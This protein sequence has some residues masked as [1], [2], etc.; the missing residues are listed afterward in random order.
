M[1]CVRLSGPVV[2]LS[3]IRV[4]LRWAIVG[5]HVTLSHG[6]QFIDASAS[7]ASNARWGRT[8]DDDDSTATTMT[9]QH[10]DGSTTR[11]WQHSTAMAARQEVMAMQETELPAVMTAPGHGLT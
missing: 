1:Q 6:G 5:A 10:G 8:I 9:A 11:R 2:P 7:G 3:A 4:E